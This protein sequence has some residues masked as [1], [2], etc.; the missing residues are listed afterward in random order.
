MPILVPEWSARSRNLERSP[1]LPCPDRRTLA[2][3]RRWRSI[4]GSRSVQHGALDGNA[5]ITAPSCALMTTFGCMTSTTI[6]R[7]L[8]TSDTSRE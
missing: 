5:V 4:F 1:L 2:E 6:P 3:H 7:T 8:S